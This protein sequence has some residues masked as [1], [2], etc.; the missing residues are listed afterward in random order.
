MKKT[1]TAVCLIS[2]CAVVAL[3]GESRIL[4]ENIPCADAERIVIEAGVGDVEITAGEGETVSVE[5]ALKPRR[6]GIFSSM[7]RAQKDVDQ[8]VLDVEVVGKDVRLDVDSD[9]D[10]PRFEERW[11]VTIPARL[12]VDLELGVGDVEI[13]GVAGGVDIEAGVGDLLLTASSG[14]LT[15]DLGVGDATITAPADQYRSAVCSSGVG[16]AR[17]K[18]QGQRIASDGFV[19]HESRW[20]SGDGEFKVKVDLG[21]GGGRITLE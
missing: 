6:G 9:S 2:L 16:D 12:A 21:V 7:K 20:S 10:D 11:T 18:V 3:A 17:L 13:R 5:V 19:G 15:V 8:A 1:L 14:D 4:E